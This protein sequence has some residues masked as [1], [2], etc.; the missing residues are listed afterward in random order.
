M[1][2]SFKGNLILSLIAT[3]FLVGFIFIDQ[4]KAQE[5]VEESQIEAQETSNGIRI[6]IS[7]SGPAKF[8]SFWLDDPP[9]LVVEFQSRNILSKIDDEVIVDQGVIKRITSSYFGRKKD[10]SLKSLTFEFTENVPYKIWQGEGA[11]LLDIE[12]ASVGTSMFTVGDKEIVIEDTAK[13][14]IIERLDAMDI[15]L[16]QAAGAQVALETPEIEIKEGILEEID[17]PEEEIVPPKAE[18]PLIAVLEP[19]APTRK[20]KGIWGMAF[21]L[22]GLALISGLGFLTWRRHRVGYNQRLEK[23]KLELQEKNKRIEQEEAIR[24]AVE[25]AALQKE[26]EHKKLKLELQKKSNQLKETEAIW[27]TSEK[28]VLEKGKEY[29]Q[30]KDSYDSLEDLLIKKGVVKKALTS[31]GKEELWIPGES[32]E[33]RV[34]PRLPLTKDYNKTIIARVESSN[35]SHLRCF[36]NDVNS[37]GLCFGAEKEFKEKEPINLRLFFF[38]DRVPMIKVRA[39]I[40]WKRKIDQINYYG[41]SFDLIDEKDKLELDKYVESK[42][43][44][45]AEALVEA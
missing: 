3:I 31:E 39:R 13:D 37:G 24:K 2:V 43:N 10:K 45:S 29:K 40:A 42:I 6:I 17:K 33:R 14:A 22:A 7:T 28:T 25:K 26:S 44:Q 16:M 30:L 9:S 12:T 8:T 15:A 19:A 41:V 18:V 4:A 35:K 32:K 20:K 34:L 5:Q 36:V 27:E 21:W 11:I 38:G 1:R 23:L